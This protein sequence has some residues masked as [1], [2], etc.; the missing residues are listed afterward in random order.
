[1]VRAMRLVRTYPMSRFESA[2]AFKRGLGFGQEERSV[3]QKRLI[4]QVGLEIQ[5][6]FEEYKAKLNSKLE[7]Q[8]KGQ[9]GKF[10]NLY[11]FTEVISE[12]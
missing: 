5:A 4:S 8:Q 6:K 2:G 3:A 9:T 7:K 1:M 12:I 11:R 10:T